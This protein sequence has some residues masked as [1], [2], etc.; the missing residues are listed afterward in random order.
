MESI[1]EFP[2]PLIVATPFIMFNSQGAY[3][4]V[5]IPPGEYQ[6][7]RVKRGKGDEDWICVTFSQGEA[8]YIVGMVESSFF[9]RIDAYEGENN[10]PLYI[11]KR[12]V[13][14]RKK[15]YLRRVKK[16][17]RATFI[18]SEQKSDEEL[19]DDSFY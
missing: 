16:T 13:S 8:V 5:P 4:E 9:R 2:E 7:Y 18:A 3:E 12:H 15:S 11:R 1:E 17:Q 10:P 14:Q 19:E 6:L